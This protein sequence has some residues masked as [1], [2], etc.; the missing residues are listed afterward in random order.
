[1]A[2]V[3][4]L[5]R[6][7]WPFK[8]CKEDSIL[9]LYFHIHQSIPTW[10]NIVSIAIESTKRENRYWTDNTYALP[11]KLIK[12]SHAM[13]TSLW[14]CRQHFKFIFYHCVC[15]DVLPKCMSIHMPAW[16]YIDQKRALDTVELELPI[17]VIH[18][19]GAKNWTSV[20]WKNSQLLTA[21]LPLQLQNFIFVKK[22]RIL[23]DSMVVF[24]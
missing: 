14:E 23:T 2:T 21:D 12:M 5:M 16:W 3:F 8:C 1:M 6:R 11:H 10:S 9:C 4:T 13:A 18:C 17:I 15:M 24:A 19:V 7:L 20:L 22:R